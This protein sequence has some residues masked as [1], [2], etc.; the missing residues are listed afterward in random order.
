MFSR[1]YGHLLFDT[2]M[3]FHFMLHFII[4]I[5]MLI[6][7][8]D[9]LK[10]FFLLNLFLYQIDLRYYMSFF[11]SW[12]FAFFSFLFDVQINELLPRQKKFK[13]LKAQLELKSYDLSL[14]QSRAEQNEHHKVVQ[15]Y[16]YFLIVVVVMQ[17]SSFLSYHLKLLFFS[18]VI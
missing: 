15:P 4:F 7:S 13:E 12:I 9:K 2:V 14:F 17:I 8:S 11:F 5:L 1:V 10:S 6:W 18:Y 3:N 16:Y